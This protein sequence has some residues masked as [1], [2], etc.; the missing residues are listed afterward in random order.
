MSEFKVGDEVVGIDG[1][2]PKGPNVVMRIGPAI[3]SKEPMLWLGENIGW[4][5][6]RFKKV[7]DHERIF[8]P[9]PVK[10]EEGVD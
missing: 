9:P 10:M 2:A 3:S 4:Y 5:A 1:I 8:F 6:Y 7:P